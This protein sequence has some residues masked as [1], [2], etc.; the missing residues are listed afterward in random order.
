VAR[1]LK[2]AVKARRVRLR[3]INAPVSGKRPVDAEK[4]DRKVRLVN[5]ML[6]MHERLAAARSDAD[7]TRLERA[8]TARFSGR[9]C[10][11]TPIL[12]LCGRECGV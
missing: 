6:D 3:R 2:P 10:F 7:R 5:E 12:V 4:R 9:Y 11:F 1:R 8:D